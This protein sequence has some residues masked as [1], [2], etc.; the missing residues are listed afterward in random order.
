MS[1][2]RGGTSCADCPAT[3]TGHADPGPG[4][5]EITVRWTPGVDTRSTPVPVT[6]WTGRLVTTRIDQTD[7]YQGG[8]SWTLASRATRSH[9][10]TGLTP[11]Q[12]Y[13]D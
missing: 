11:G 5:G 3:P 7:R 12:E 2:S 8:Q 4:P 1:L 6:G 9:V 10:F 13:A